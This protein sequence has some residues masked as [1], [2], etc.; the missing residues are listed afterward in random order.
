MSNNQR[1]FVPNSIQ[2]RIMVTSVYDNSDHNLESIGG[3]T[4]H[5]TN[6]III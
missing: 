3:L 5:A 4:M 1:N 2:S 6:G